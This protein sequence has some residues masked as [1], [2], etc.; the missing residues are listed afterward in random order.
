[1]T[2]KTDISAAKISAMKAKDSFRSQT[3]GSILA[4]IKQH[5]VDK[6]QDVDSDILINILN[7]M[8]K[9]R[10]ESITQFTAANRIDLVD[11]EEKE[12]ALIKEFLPEEASQEKIDEVIALAIAN[13][14]SSTLKDMGKIM[15]IV[16]GELNGQADMSKVSQQIKSKLS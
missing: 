4:A 15:A 16:K 2:N 10:Q 14:G 1:M 7:R 5:E 13:V 12:L 3:L 8:V 6:R 11:V 9:Q